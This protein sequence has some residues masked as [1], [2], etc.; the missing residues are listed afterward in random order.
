MTFVQQLAKRQA[1]GF[2][3]PTAQAKKLGWWDPLPSLSALCHNDSSHLGTSR[4]PW[5]SGR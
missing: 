1:V 5:T 2:R 3:L 4:A